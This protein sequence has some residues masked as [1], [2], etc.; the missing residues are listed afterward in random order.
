MDELDRANILQVDQLAFNV[1]ALHVGQLGSRA[2]IT[3]RGIGTENASITGEPGVAFHVD[4]VNHAR[5]SL[6]ALP[7]FDLEGLEVRRGPQGS[8]GGKN[9]T[10]GA[11]HLRTRKPSAEFESAADVQWGSYS[12]RR[13]RAAMNLP[14]N[15]YAQTRFAFYREDRAG[16]QRNFLFND[17]DR[18]AFDADDFGWRGH[19]RLLPRDDLEVVTTYNYFERNGVGPQHELVGL[20]ADRR[21]NPFPPPLGRNF[22]P[23]THLP[24]ATGCSANPDRKLYAPTGF[25]LEGNRHF[26]GFENPQTA[27]VS[28]EVATAASRTPHQIFLDSAPAQDNRF[29]GWTGTLNWDLPALGFLGE[30]SLKSITSI[31]KVELDSS[32]D[33]DATDIDFLVDRVAQQTRQRSQ[34]LQW[35]GDLGRLDWQLSLLWFRETGESNS[36]VMAVTDASRGINSD[37]TVENE[38]YSAALSTRYALTDSV[39]LRVGG[40]Y[41]VEQRETQLLQSGHILE[42]FFG[43]LLFVCNGE[44]DDEKGLMIPGRTI[45]FGDGQPDDGNPNCQRTDRQATGD[46]TLEWQATPGNLFYGKL[47]NGFKAGGLNADVPGDYEPEKI[48]AFA[49]GSKSVLFSDRL[50]LNLEGYFYNYRDLQLVHIA[51]LSR[52]TDNADAEIGGVDLEFQLEPVA[53]LRLNGTASWTDSRLTEYNAIDPIDISLDSWCRLFRFCAA[54]DYSGRE[55]ARAPEF[56]LMLGAEYEVSLKQFG[57]LTPRIQYYWQDETWFR[58]FNRTRADSGVNAGCPPAAVGVRSLCGPNGKLH[59]SAEARDLQDSYHLTDIRLTWTS[60]DERWSAEAFVTNLEDELV[61]Q[62]LLVGQPILDSPQYAWYGAP[63]QYGFRVGFRY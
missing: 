28:R 5:P 40:R 7:F 24:A 50:T 26:V 43:R 18:D 48:W 13:F 49:L 60:P 47:T 9:S 11:I 2:I 32:V 57:S 14:L 23:L 63:R 16:F 55:L 4:G 30:S 34:E 35:S 62:N 8:R 54:T 45:E 20:E 53:G 58:P 31:Q 61:Y 56:S 33:D 41:N 10:A 44:A 51:G 29:W 36:V 1:P 6:A 22:N 17:D 27:G 42:S 59:S 38:S 25:D 39:S 21:C 19:L 46:L 15:E 52:R 12:Q 37:Q 3:L